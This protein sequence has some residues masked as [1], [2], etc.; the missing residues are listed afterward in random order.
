MKKFSIMT[1]TAYLVLTTIAGGVVLSGLGLS[2]LYIAKYFKE[3]PEMIKLGC[4][5]GI[6]LPEC[7]QTQSKLDALRDTLSSLEDKAKVVQDKLDDAESKLSRLRNVESQIDEAMLFE[8][9][10]DPTTKK[11]ITIGTQY[12]KLIE[13]EKNPEFFCYFNLGDDDSGASR[14]YYFKPSSIFSFFEDVKLK[15]LGFSD[16]TIEFA[17]SIC[18]PT[19]IGAGQ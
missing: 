11:T 6:E 8:F 5:L 12:T 13:P 16:K 3:T 15:K 9:H 4:F 18:K 17:R 1:L 19:L 7:P 2:G 14:S 10:I